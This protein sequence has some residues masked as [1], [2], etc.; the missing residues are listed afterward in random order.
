MSI[1]RPRHRLG[2]GSNHLGQ[3][4]AREGSHALDHRPIEQIFPGAQGKKFDIGK[5]AEKR[6]TMGFDPILRLP[7][8][9]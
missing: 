4:R 2:R 8:E 6:D 7:N 1:V 3:V 9:K 5:P